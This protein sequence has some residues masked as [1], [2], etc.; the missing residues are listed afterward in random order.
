MEEIDRSIMNEIESLQKTKVVWSFLRD[1]PESSKYRA[2]ARFGLSEDVADCP[3]CEYAH[4]NCDICPLKTF[5]AETSNYNGEVLPNTAIACP[6]QC[7]GTPYEKWANANSFE[8][9][10][11]NA[12]KM[13]KACDARIE[14]I[15]A[16]RSFFSRIYHKIFG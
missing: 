1:N 16:A 5:W 7:I 9:K 3:L 6:C 12:D 13:V 11:D 8:V 2:Y 4:C 15:H 14:A 10:S